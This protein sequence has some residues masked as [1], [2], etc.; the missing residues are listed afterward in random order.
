MVERGPKQ[1]RK[2]C[3]SHL[4]ERAD[5]TTAAYRTIPALT[6]IMLPT[7]P[8]FYAVYFAGNASSSSLELSLLRAPPAAVRRLWLDRWQF[9]HAQRST[10]LVTPRH[11]Q[12]LQEEQFIEPSFSVKSQRS[13][14][15]MRQA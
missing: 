15:G 8:C 11:F 2:R 7:G 4:R 1:P 6:R 13:R 12:V 5:L 3:I 10:W 9:F 14:T